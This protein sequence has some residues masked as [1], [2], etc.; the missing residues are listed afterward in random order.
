MPLSYDS[1][2]KI[3][4]KNSIHD[5]KRKSSSRQELKPN[6]LMQRYIDGTPLRPRSV[7]IGDLNLTV[8]ELLNPT[9][10]IE[11]WMY[12]DTHVSSCS[13]VDRELDPF[14]VV[15]WPGAQLL[16][17]R[18]LSPP[19]GKSLFGRRVLCLGAGTGLEVHSFYV[20]CL[21]FV[22]S[23]FLFCL[24]ALAALA[25][26]ASVTATDTNPLVLRLLRLAAADLNPREGSLRTAFFDILDPTAKTP[27]SF[28]A[29]EGEGEVG[30]A[31]P[32]AGDLID[33]FPRTSLDLLR[34]C[35]VLVA[36]DCIYNKLLARGLARCCLDA[37][38]GGNGTVGA[39]H[40][41]AADSQGFHRADF[42][43]ALVE[44]WERATL[45]RSSSR[46]ALGVHRTDKSSIESVCTT[47]ENSGMSSPPPLEAVRMNNV[48]GSGLILS[49]DLE[50]NIT[51][52]VLHLVS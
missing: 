41:L 15:L 17:T 30:P 39:D 49:G 47:S 9:E 24:Q 25:M 14:G 12:K 19:L 34:S 51:V 26:G 27:L 1:K 28:L 48:R 40:V 50:Y 35:D 10:M 7:S 36:A 2:F 6:T 13:S 21:D 23:D 37:W 43:D 33:N 20:D 4:Q 11:G 44:G 52:H 5:F 3:S 18:L 8:W 22:S 38:A 32:P 45:A 16:A 46:S 29:E 42:W 31:S